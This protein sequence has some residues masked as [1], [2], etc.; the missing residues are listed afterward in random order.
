MCCWLMRSGRWSACAASRPFADI[1]W[2]DGTTRDGVVI[3]ARDR[4]L[5]TLGFIL[6]MSLLVFVCWW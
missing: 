3:G 5:Q 2:S 1:E 4:R 6:T